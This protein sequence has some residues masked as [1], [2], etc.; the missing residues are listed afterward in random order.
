MA[1]LD[2]DGVKILAYLIKNINAK[3]NLLNYDSS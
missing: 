2:S 1:S 3:E